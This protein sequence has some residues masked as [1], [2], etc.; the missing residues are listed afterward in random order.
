M[1]L[2]KTLRHGKSLGLELAEQQSNIRKFYIV[3][4]IGYALRV[5]VQFLYGNY[6][7][8]VK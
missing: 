6:H 2:E 1:R 5:P 8:L 4:C 3:M 7:I